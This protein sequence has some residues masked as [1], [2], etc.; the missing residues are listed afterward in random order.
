MGATLNF[1]TNSIFC[2]PFRETL[3]TLTN[4]GKRNLKKEEAKANCK[5]YPRSR[6]QKEKWYHLPNPRQKPQPHRLHRIQKKSMQY[7]GQVEKEIK[8]RLGEHLRKI[9]PKMM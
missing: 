9:L 3:E 6:I 8:S 5:R 4:Q 2:G 1:D 7:M